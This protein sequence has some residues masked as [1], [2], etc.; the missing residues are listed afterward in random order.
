MDD[1]LPKLWYRQDVLLERPPME[2]EL[3]MGANPRVRV[4]PDHTLVLQNV[5]SADNA[6]YHCL[7]YSF[8]LD[9][10]QYLVRYFLSAW[11]LCEF[12]MWE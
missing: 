8:L 2:V 10:K 12:L 5:T 4:T 3:D 11:A 7:E 6:V 9:G 1:P